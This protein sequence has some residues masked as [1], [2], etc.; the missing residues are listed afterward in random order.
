MST[1]NEKGNPLC[2]L[3]PVTAPD[4]DSVPGQS[5]SCSAVKPAGPEQV[6]VPLG[7]KPLLRTERW[8]PGSLLAEEEDPKLPAWPQPEEHLG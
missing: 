7:R 1:L 3:E 5:L 8:R 6:G 4:S 2:W